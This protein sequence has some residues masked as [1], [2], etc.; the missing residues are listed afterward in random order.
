MAQADAEDGQAPHENA[1]LLDGVVVFCR[2]AGA[3][4]EHH[5][6]HVQTHHI[7]G[8]HVMRQ[9]D[10]LAAPLAEAAD[11]VLLRPVVDEGHPESFLSLR[12]KDLWLPVAHLGHRPGT[13]IGGDGFQIGGRSGEDAGVHDALFPDDAG[14]L[15][16]VHPADAA[17]A[18]VFQK[19][20]QFVL[21]AEVGG[22]V[23]QLPNH[24]AFGKALPLKIRLDHPVVADEGEG[25]H[26]DLPGVAG[27][28]EGLQIALHPGGKH[29]LADAVARRADGLAL[30]DH[31]VA[32]YKIGFFHRL[33]P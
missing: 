13:G 31:A 17:D 8:G 10:H 4:G 18:P 11:N 27:V 19:F 1:D 9:A 22:G 5:P 14:D 32:Q 25:L 16:G 21:A 2:V 28:G 6:V 15:P 33:P 23:A 30:K 24:I 26:D 3:V 7:P 20:I 12:E 29:Q